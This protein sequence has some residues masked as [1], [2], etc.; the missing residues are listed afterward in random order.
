MCQKDVAS[1]KGKLVHVDPAPPALGYLLGEHLGAS[2]MSGNRTRQQWLHWTS[3]LLLGSVPSAHLASILATTFPVKCRT[4]EVGSS[5][6]SG[7]MNP[8]LFSASLTPS[9]PRACSYHVADFLFPHL[10]GA[11]P[12][13][14]IL[15]L[16]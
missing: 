9:L 2:L 7:S 5:V 10:S 12:L 8:L 16:F 13:N 6:V 4:E 15:H 3:S 11:V 1:S 14:Y